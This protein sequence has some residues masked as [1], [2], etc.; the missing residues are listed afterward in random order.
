M[1]RYQ[2]KFHINSY[3]PISDTQICKI[4]IPVAIHL[5][6]NILISRKREAQNLLYNSW[7][8]VIYLYRQDQELSVNLIW[9]RERVCG[10]YHD[11]SEN[12]QKSS[13][14]IHSISDRFSIYYG[15]TGKKKY[16]LLERIEEYIHN[17]LPQA[18]HVSE[19]SLSR[20]GMFI[21]RHFKKYI[22]NNMY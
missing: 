14:E 19:Y 15:M 16:Y 20:S 9:S 17:N 13:V 8:L 5:H 12:I 2:V 4:F 11:T 10:S 18:Y 1:E 3:Q 7:G 21:P 6:I 22:H